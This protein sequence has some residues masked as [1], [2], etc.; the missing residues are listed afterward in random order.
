MLKKSSK[1]DSCYQSCAILEGFA[2]RHRAGLVV[3]KL[4]RNK[5][6]MRATVEK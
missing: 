3:E 4:V 2:L 6:E 1:D 5:K